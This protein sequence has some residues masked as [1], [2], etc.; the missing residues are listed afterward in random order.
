[1]KRI[2]FA[3]LCVVLIAAPAFAQEPQITTKAGT[4]TLGGALTFDIDMVIPD[5]GDSTTGFQLNVLPTVGYFLM[6]NLELEGGVLF[7]MGF[8]DLYED[9][10]MNLGFGVG[11]KYFIPMGR[12]AIYVGADIAMTFN[13]PDEGDTT[14]AL[15][16]AVPAGILYAMNQWV[17][18]DLGLRFTY[19]MSLEDGGGSYMTI[20]IGYFGIQ[21]F[22]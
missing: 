22:F 16:I 10:G 3:V 17:A 7:N 6:D 12:M 14:K 13:V 19:N 9:A 2:I 5:E 21:A 8:G 18:L 15:A 1:M 20:P 11:A 4:M